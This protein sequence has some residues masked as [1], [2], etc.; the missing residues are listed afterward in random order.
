MT[1]L[2]LPVAAM[3]PIFFG[4]LLRMWTDRGKN[5]EA[6]ADHGVLLGSGFVAGEGLIG[7]A[8]AGI[9]LS[10][11]RVPEGVGYGWAG[12]GAM[13]ASAALFA[14]LIAWFWHSTRAAVSSR[15]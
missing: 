4:G 7:V 2:Y 12:G 10:L 14:A 9:A 3:V 8:I 5:A 15:A 11:G 13:W 6:R 1:A